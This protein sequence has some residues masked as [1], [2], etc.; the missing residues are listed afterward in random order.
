MQPRGEVAIT[1]MGLLTPAGLDE[2]TIWKVMTAG[3]SLARTDEELAGLPVDIAC[4]VPDFEPAYELGGRLTRRLDRFMHLGLV[5]ARRAVTDAGLATADVGPDRVGV[6]LGVGSNSVQQY[7]KEFQ[8]LREGRAREVSPLTVPRSVPNM[9][10][11]EVAMDLVAHGPNFVVSSACASG[12]TALGVAREMLLAGACDVVLA[13]GAE[14]GRTPMTAACFHQLR[15]LSRNTEHP[16][17]ACR[18]FDT[19]RDGFV[20]GE[21]A[22]VLVLERAEHA[23]ARSVRPRAF[24]RGYGASADAYSSVAPHPGGDGATL[25]VRRAL[26]DA[27]CVPGDVGH[28]SAHG[29][30]TRLGDAAE[31]RTL[32]RVFGANAPPATAAKSVVGHALGAAGAI[33]AAL[34]VLALEYEEVPPTANLTLQDPGGELDVVATRPRALSSD[35]ALSTSFAFGGQNTALVLTAP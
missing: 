19:H 14:S 5:A 23:R 20:L 29:T 15:A 16:E 21:G 11:A 30:A 25:A 12:S 2:D 4:R 28:I 6:I 26:D 33:E 34:T 17:L 3:R 32:L 1:G 18:P 8:H 31:V 22:A 24:L 35:V 13:G 7:P 9:A 10:A 27:G